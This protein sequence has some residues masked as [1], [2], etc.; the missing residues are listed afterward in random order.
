MNRITRWSAAALG[1]ALVALVATPIAQAQPRPVPLPQP[2]V[3]AIPGGG[4]D[5]FRALL[6]REGIRPL[7][8]HELNNNWNLGND[9]IVIVIGSL[10][11]NIW[12]VDARNLIQGTL[13]TG[14]A[15]LLASDSWVHLQDTAGN[16]VGR[17]NGNFVRARQPA[18]Y[19]GGFDDC[20]FVVPV[21][22]KERLRDA[23][24][25]GR[26]W[27]LFRGVNRLVTNQPTYIEMDHYQ[28]EYQYPLARLPNSSI[29]RAPGGWDQPLPSP[30]FAVG[31]DG[32]NQWNGDPGYSFLAVA[33]SSIYINQMIMER[34]TDNL[35]FTLRTIDYLQG[36]DKQRKR[37]AFIE[38]GRVV[39]KFDGLKQAMMNQQAKIPPDKVPNLGPLIDKNQDKLV[40]LGNR[41]ADQI[42]SKDGL[43]NM[44]VGREGTE[45]ERRQFSWWLERVAVVLAVVVSLLLLRR[46]LSAR[47]PTAVPPPPSTGAGAASTGPPGVFERRQKELVRRNN[48]YEPVRNLM[49]EFFDSVGA[50]PNPGPRLPRL[51]IDHRQVRK[52]ESLRHAVRDMWR[53]AYGPPMYLSAQRWFELE[54]YFE[55][56]RQAHVDGKWRFATDEDV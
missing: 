1:A 12:G 17:F 40:D 19:Y 56:L 22:P 6:D 16:G 54:P 46:T 8:P 53:I 42:Q 25:P 37:C 35:E 39:D 26:V 34:D 7:A 30:V 2:P 44:L 13:R 28:G 24:K 50:P 33:D 55:R 45:Q 29:V 4:T 41:L 5:L 31:G 10:H 38:N 14:G 21:S 32:P 36:P 11:Q 20:P 47:A 23:D 9:L 27:G 52:P 48:L 43:H 49:R 18:D 3:V 15:V 51:I